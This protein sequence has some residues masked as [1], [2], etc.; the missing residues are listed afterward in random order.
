LLFKVLSGV[1]L[2]RKLQQSGVWSFFEY[3]SDNLRTNLYDFAT[4]G[5][6]GIFV[7]K[8]ERKPLD[9]FDGV[10]DVMLKNG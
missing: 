9:F 7:F 4:I 3:F 10:M 5:L 2:K 1:S 6:N 8:T